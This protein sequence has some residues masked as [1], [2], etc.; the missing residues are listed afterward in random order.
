MDHVK[1]AERAEQTDRGPEKRGLS[2]K[3]IHP[4]QLKL[5]GPWTYNKESFQNA[6]TLWSGLFSVWCVWRILPL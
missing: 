3:T 4:F 6:K 5:D 2:T 1:R